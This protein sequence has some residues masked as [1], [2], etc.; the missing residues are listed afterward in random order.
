MSLVSSSLFGSSINVGG[1][2]I[3]SAFF[4][5]TSFPFLLPSPLVEPFTLFGFRLE[6]SASSSNTNRQLSYD[7]SSWSLSRLN[8]IYWLI[9]ILCSFKNTPFLLFMSVMYPL[10][11]LMTSL[12]WR[13]DTERSLRT[14]PHSLKLRP[15][16]FC[17]YRI[18]TCS[19]ESS[20]VQTI[21]QMTFP[22]M[23]FTQKQV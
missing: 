14:T 21:L 11:S 23:Q 5:Y 16:M 20:L 4:V 17:P 3:F 13:C 8:S 15:I 12:Q 2:L 18:L 19:V 9:G 10:L 1:L 7:I 6:G 22:S